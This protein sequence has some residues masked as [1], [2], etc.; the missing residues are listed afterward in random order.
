MLLKIYQLYQ[1]IRNF[2]NKLNEKH[3]SA[4]AAKTAY[5]IMLSFIPFLMLLFTMIQFIEVDKTDVQLLFAGAVPSTIEPLLNSIIDEIYG[6]SSTVISLSALAT[7]WT[8]GKG[9]TA[10]IQGLNCVFDVKETR[11]YIMLRIYGAFYTILMLVAVIL[12]MV[13][14]VFGNKLKIFLVTIVP[15]IDRVVTS[16]LRFRYVISMLVLVVMFAMIYCYMPNKKLRLKGQFPGAMFSAISWSLFSYG[17]SLYVDYFG[18]MSNMYGSLT[19]MVVVMLWLYMCMYIM[20][21]GAMVNTMLEEDA[22]HHIY[23]N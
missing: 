19:T 8:A 23:S 18:N 15:F 3:V 13:L 1:R 4:Y 14:V 11:N 20:L 6:K 21:I 10:V 12:L 2:L 22:E 7:L 5:F 17:F 9:I 16:I